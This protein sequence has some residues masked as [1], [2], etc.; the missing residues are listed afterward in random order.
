MSSGRETRYCRCICR[1][2]DILHGSAEVSV[3]TCDHQ[4]FTVLEHHH[5]MIVASYSSCKCC[6]GDSNDHPAQF[7]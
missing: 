6:A 2:Q 7:P 5:H 1:R 4:G 3:H